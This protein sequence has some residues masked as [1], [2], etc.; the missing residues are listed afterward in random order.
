MRLAVAPTV[1][2]IVGV[3]WLSGSN[4]QFNP[5]PNS[6]PKPT[7]DHKQNCAMFASIMWLGSAH[8]GIQV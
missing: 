3:L 8:H 7:V 6:S 1:Q 5:N 4:I 2:H